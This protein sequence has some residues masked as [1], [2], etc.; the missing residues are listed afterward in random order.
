[1]LTSDRFKPRGNARAHSAIH[2]GQIQLTARPSDADNLDHGSHPPAPGR[3]HGRRSRGRGG[4][5][6]RKRRTSDEEA[7]HPD[8][9]RHRLH[10]PAR[11]ATTRSRAATR[12]PCSTAAGRRNRGRA[13]SRSCSATATPATSRRWPGRDVGRLHR[14]PHH[15][16]LLGARR[17]QG[18]ERQGRPVHLHLDHLGLR[19][20]RHA[21]ADESAALVPY[22]GKDPMAETIQ[23]FSAPAG[24]QLYGP[25]KASAKPRRGDSSA[26]R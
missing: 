22:T 11:G 25:L 8:P 19:R 23:T 6:L 14:Q 24:A 5:R 2:G 4:A 26:R 15:P 13:R 9:R 20:Q 17:R 7:A 16:A 21:G 3:A 18:A 12:S 10:R 1:M